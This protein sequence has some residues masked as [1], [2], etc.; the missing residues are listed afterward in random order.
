VAAEFAQRL[1]TQS[2]Y[3]PR[4]ALLEHRFAELLPEL[5]WQIGPRELAAIAG[6]LIEQSL[7]GP[8]TVTTDHLHASAVSVA[9]QANLISERLRRSQT[10]SFADLV[11]DVAHQ[12]SMVVA[13]FLALL[14]LYRSGA[15]AFDQLEALGPLTV[16]W[17]GLDRTVSVDD[18]YAG[19][20]GSPDD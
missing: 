16:R 12:P 7:S 1:A 13:R 3:H 15:L 11:A 10:A 19:T 9:E 6:R 4:A 17:V 18:E 20:K 2:R 5:V 14:E 8:P